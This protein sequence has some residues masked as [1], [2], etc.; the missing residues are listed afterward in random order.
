[1]PTERTYDYIQLDVIDTNE[2][3]KRLYERKGFEQTQVHKFPYLKGLLGFGGVTTMKL[4]TS[5]KA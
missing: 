2:G 3:A 1:M 4:S 5:Y